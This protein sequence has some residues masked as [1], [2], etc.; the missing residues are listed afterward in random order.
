[1]SIFGDRLRALRRQAIAAGMRLL[2][3]EEIVGG[4]RRPQ[5]ASA[6][7]RNLKRLREAKG[8]SPTQ[9]ASKAKISAST[10]RGMEEP[11]NRH[12][13]GMRSNPNPTLTSMLA[14]AAAL[15][16]GIEALVNETP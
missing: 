11:G 6:L 1:V 5:S 9:L 12:L 3:E 8:W 4:E 14:V 13:G 15:E 2:S 7:P 16:C 10:V